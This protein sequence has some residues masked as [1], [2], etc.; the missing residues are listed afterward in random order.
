MFFLLQNGYRV[1]AHDRRRFGRLIQPSGGCEIPWPSRGL[2]DQ[3][4]GLF[5]AAP[6]L[7]NQDDAISLTDAL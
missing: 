3:G 4:Q 5:C 6:M 1:I 7:A 2:P